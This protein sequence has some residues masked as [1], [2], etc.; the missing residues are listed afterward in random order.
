MKNHVAIPANIAVKIVA[1]NNEFLKA[2][3]K[4]LPFP[5]TTNNVPIIEDIFFIKYAK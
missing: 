4:F 1:K 5:K 2:L 3:Y